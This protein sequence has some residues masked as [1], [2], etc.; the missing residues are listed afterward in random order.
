MRTEEEMKQPTHDDYKINSDKYSIMLA[1]MREKAIMDEQSSLSWARKEA[2]REAIIDNLRQLGNVHQKL[3]SIINE[4]D[5]IE[6]L[7]SW[8]RIAIISKSIDE[9][10]EKI[11]ED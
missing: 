8:I 7:R 2:L 4:Q 11:N 1:E 3:I 10:E 6:I 5:N 9:F